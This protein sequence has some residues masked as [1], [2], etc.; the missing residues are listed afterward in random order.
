MFVTF[1]EFLDVKR[2]TYRSQVFNNKSMEHRKVSHQSKGAMTGK[3]TRGDNNYGNGPILRGGR[4][5]NLM[6]KRFL[7]IYHFRTIKTNC[8]VAVS[9]SPSEARTLLQHTKHFWNGLWISA[10]FTF[11]V[12][13]SYIVAYISDL[14]ICYYLVCGA[15]LFLLKLLYTYVV[16]VRSLNTFKVQRTESTRLF[17]SNPDWGFTIFSHIE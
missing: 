9:K 4:S 7:K 2:F 3:N 14:Q 11:L 15:C 17:P 10:D 13:C 6:V 8:W 1:P 5:S 12:Q 16:S